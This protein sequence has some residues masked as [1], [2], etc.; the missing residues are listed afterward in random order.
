MRLTLFLFCLITAFVVRDAGAQTPLRPTDELASMFAADQADRVETGKPVDWV[1]VS[2][3]DEQREARV[4]QLLG[5][6]KLVTGADYYHAAMIL[7]HAPTPDDSLLAHDL[8]VIAISKGEPRAKWLAAASL[9]RYL[10]RIGRPQRYA[11]QF[12]ASRPGRPPRLYP[13]DPSVPDSLR[14]E[15]DV[16]TLK[17]AQAREREA[18]DQAA[19]FL[20]RTG[21]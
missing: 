12:G 7:Q 1:A 8:C 21:K 11:T 20:K 3:R 2:S 18:A 15:L 6:G 10:M 9:D 16:P 4:K 14:R 17:E 5:E 19:A 13:V